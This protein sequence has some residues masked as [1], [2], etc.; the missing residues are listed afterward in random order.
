M[1]FYKSIEDLKKYFI[2]FIEKFH[3]LENHLF[4]WTM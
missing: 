3:H 4:V 1:D 2:Q